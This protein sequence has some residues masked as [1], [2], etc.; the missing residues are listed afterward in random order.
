MFYGV[1]KK[2]FVVGAYRVVALFRFDCFPECQSWSSRKASAC[3][4]SRLSVPPRALQCRGRFRPLPNNPNG[5]LERENETLCFLTGSPAI[6]VRAQP[7]S[8]SA[9]RHHLRGRGLLAS[10]LAGS[11]EGARSEPREHGA[12][13]VGTSRDVRVQDSPARPRRGRLLVSSG[14]RSASRNH[15]RRC[16]PGG[17]SA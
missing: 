6:P 5:V 8:A 2:A 10:S 15:C 16:D 11:R 3:N 14:R 1:K 7:R 13:G 12:V 4:S 17:F 9:L